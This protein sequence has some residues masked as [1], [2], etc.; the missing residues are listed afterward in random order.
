MKSAKINALRIFAL[1]MCLF[2]FLSSCG[3]ETVI[4]SEIEYSD[5]DYEEY[6]DFDD[7]DDSPEK[8]S[9][10]K[11][12]KSSSSKKK[13]TSSVA[14]VSSKSTNPASSK[15]ADTSTVS[16]A[17][18]PD[19][20]S[21]ADYIKTDSNGSNKVVIY[22][23]TDDYKSTNHYKVEVKVGSKWLEAPVYYAEV[24]RKNTDV[25]KTYFAS[26]DLSGKMTVRVTPNFK[27]SS[28]EVK[29]KVDVP[30]CKTSG[31]AVEFSVN[32]NCQLSVE[33]DG[34]NMENLQLFVNPPEKNIP[35]KNDPNVIFVTPGYHTYKDSY[36]IDYKVNKDGKAT[37]TVTLASGQTL[38]IA[39]GAVLEAQ[40]V[41]KEK[42]ENVTVRGRGI[43][44][45]LN[46][47]SESGTYDDTMK[48]NSEYPTGVR[49]Y[50]GKNINIEGLV[51]RNPWNFCIRG[52]ALSNF[53]VD[54]IK[55]FSRGQWSDGI[56]IWASH[57]INIKNCYIRSN[58]DGVAVYA[59]RNG[60]SGSSYNWK[61]NNCV[62]L[63]DCAH[64]VNIGS[65]GSQKED[66]RDEIR[67]ITFSDIDI[68][69][70]FENST[71][72]WGA[73]G[74]TVGDENHVHDITFDNI[75]MYQL[76]KSRPITVSIVKYN[77]NPTPGYLIEN[78]IFKNI[79][80]YSKTN[81]ISLIK[82]YKSG[83][84]NRYVKNITF[85]NFTVGGTK[86]TQ[87]NLSSY[88]KVDTNASGVTVK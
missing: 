24:K 80:L 79:T 51:F 63:I 5:D 46:Y 43:V 53:T 8:T 12:K 69:D 20:F 36:Y 26:V 77:V 48:V 31:G 83:G 7:D 2:L 11:K 34:N 28:C 45:M 85:E 71:S 1:I 10:K 84:V 23:E 50:K 76:S 4:T 59:T 44:D 66:K 75:R 19:E 13:G 78:I 14:S 54:N 29:P 82:G 72:Y 86:V 42:A 49:C 65:H 67:D 38:Y 32:G 9:S 74:F 37:P 30:S 41:I 39:G 55:I 18:A 57:D 17:D 70:V 87:S 33:F 21:Y 15:K 25:L 88:V 16:E 73:L 62:F 22:K 3:T 60:H 64:A 6:E 56:D 68:L 35:S 40:I 52:G 58:D 27:F 61:I 47:G 81:E